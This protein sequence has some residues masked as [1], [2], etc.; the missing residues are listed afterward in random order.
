VR[1]HLAIVCVC[2]LLCA[3]CGGVT[4]VT[5]KTPNP[6]AN[7]P[8]GGSGGSGSGS[9]TGTGT[10][11]G[12]GSAPGTGTGAGSGAGSGSGSGS[13]SAGAS[14]TTTL[15]E[16][17]V[18]TLYHAELSESGGTEPCVW[19][20]VSGSL[21]PG[22]ILDEALGV[23]TG[24]PTT[25]GTSSFELELIDSAGKTAS[26]NFYLTVGGG[27]WKTT[28][29][30]DATSGSDSNSGTSKSTAWKSIAKVNQTSFAPG[31]RILFKRNEIW[32]EELRVTS[33]GEQGQPIVLDA[34]AS[35]APPLIS[36]ADV[37]PA[38]A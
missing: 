36:G 14:I 31:D 27:S 1:N 22:L 5:T 3:S 7:P 13:G 38:N 26:G 4:K 6:P 12:S 32:R 30:V 8:N 33:S 28:Y 19:K 21:P 9:G 35:G 17:A 23:V 16:A 15:P 11:S 10:G 25:A 20:L 2:A 24:T 18:D 29:Y 34:Y 37:I